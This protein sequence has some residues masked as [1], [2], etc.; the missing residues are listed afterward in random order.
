MSHKWSQETMTAPA[1]SLGGELQRARI[2]HGLS[3]ADVAKETRI[4]SDYLKAIEEHHFD[5]IPYAKIYQR[6][7]IKRYAGAVELDP[8]TLSGMFDELFA[9]DDTEGKSM[10]HKPAKSYHLRFPN[11]PRIIRTILILAVV[12]LVVGYLVSQVNAMVSPPGLIIS[13][14]PNGAITNVQAIVVSGNTEQEIRVQINGEEITTSES[15]QFS[16]EIILS[17]GMNTLEIAACS[18]HGR[19]TTQVRHVTFSPES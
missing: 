12:L 18:K 3:L 14:P 6:N 13:S 15:G 16:E 8:Q 1:G 7:F 10:E 4:R 2:H 9:P 5:D 19:C 17:P 11:I